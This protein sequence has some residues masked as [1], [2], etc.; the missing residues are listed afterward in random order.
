MPRAVR[1][2]AYKA[3]VMPVRCCLEGDLLKAAARQREGRGD[4]ARGC[5]SEVARHAT[6]DGLST[7]P[8]SLPA[9]S[10]PTPH[11][12]LPQ[13]AARLPSPPLPI[14]TQPFTPEPCLPPQVTAGSGDRCVYIW[15]AATRALMYKLPGHGGS[16][17]ECVFHPRE[18]VIGSASS[19]KTIYLGELAQ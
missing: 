5:G 4:R 11:R 18:P 19:D 8:R 15:S 14:N 12:R 3:A 9:Q 17:N 13:V 2:A 16:V 6:S 7:P 1:F 10:C